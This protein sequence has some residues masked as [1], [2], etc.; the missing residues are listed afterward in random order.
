[1][2]NEFA[3]KMV[4]R[5]VYVNIAGLMTL[6]FIQGHKCVSN[7]TTIWLAIS[8][9]IFKQLHSNFD[10]TVDLWMLYML[11]LVLMTLTLKLHHSG[12]AKATNQRFML[13]AAKLAITYK[14]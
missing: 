1:M 4:Q 3:V 14:H 2:P 5:K 9:T 8:Q 13:S 7:L 10:M 11:M 6:T 12:S